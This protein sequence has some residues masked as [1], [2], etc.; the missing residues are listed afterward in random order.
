MHIVEPKI[1]PKMLKATSELLL[2]KD[3]LPSLNGQASK[4][5]PLAA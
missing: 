5:L 1:S 2:K 4:I 3:R